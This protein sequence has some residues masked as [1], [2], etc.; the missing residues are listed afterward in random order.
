MWSNSP[1]P[2]RAGALIPWP[3]G[4]TSRS[5]H[6]RPYADLF[7]QA[8]LAPEGHAIAA[9]CRACERR[10]LQSAGVKPQLE[11][12]LRGDF[13]R[14]TRR[15]IRRDGGSGGGRISCCLSKRF[16]AVTALP[17]HTREFGIR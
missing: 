6:G 12:G 13:C 7:L 10:E 9:S 16:S 5:R 15:Q 11:V 17:P 1:S 2:D 14:V 3:F 8:R 4:M